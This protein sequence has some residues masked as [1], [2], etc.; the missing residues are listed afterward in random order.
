M[1]TET[2]LKI[3][4]MVEACGIWALVFVATFFLTKLAGMKNSLP[5]VT[6]QKLD[7]YVKTLD[8]FGAK[9]AKKSDSD[10][11]EVSKLFKRVCRVQ[12]HI[13]KIF[14]VYVYDNPVSTVAQRAFDEITK[15]KSEMAVLSLALTENSIEKANASIEKTKDIVSRACS[16][17]D[18][19]AKEEDQK[20]RLKV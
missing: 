5:R 15:I 11:K 13:Q 8:Q 1:N 10:N 9:L 4:S 19:V 17:L 3:I 14:A 20:R 18:E 6:K 7:E 16:V 12:K 2:A